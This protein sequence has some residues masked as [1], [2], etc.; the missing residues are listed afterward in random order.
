M[1]NDIY[2]TLN[3]ISDEEAKF[4]SIDPDS[5]YINGRDKESIEA[6]RSNPSNGTESYHG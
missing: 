6:R 2:S 4:V 1:A 5:R 3:P